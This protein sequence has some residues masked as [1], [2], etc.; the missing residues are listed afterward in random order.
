MKRSA[1]QGPDD[2][3]I[4]AEFVLRVLK[5]DAHRAAAIRAAGDPAFAAEVRAWEDRFAPMMAEVDPVTPDPA[6]RAALLK[7][8]FGTEEPRAE[9]TRAGVWQFL[10]AIGFAAAAA[11]AVI[12]LQTP[13]PA[14]DRGPET[15]VA[16]DDS[17][18]R[19]VAELAVADNTTRLLAVIDR[20]DGQ[21]D[22]TWTARNQ[23]DDRDLQ[24]WGIP[25]D[26]APVS[27]GVLPAGDTATLPL[28]PTLIEG[29]ETVT[30]A[31]S[32][33]PLG[34]SPT[35]LPTGEVLATSPLSEI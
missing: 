3:E 35:G 5:P 11:L 17:A 33:E 30:L 8:L 13:T 14:P 7:R 2:T 12:L 22:L 31:I 27:I 15:E 4:A 10:T 28:P 20:R 19:F 9:T 32:D 29:T 23:R 34:G 24:L 21:I 25:A 18:Q 26:G 16:S 1:D 6:T